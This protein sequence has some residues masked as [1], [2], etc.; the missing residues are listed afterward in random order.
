MT[1]EARNFAVPKRVSQTIT[2]TV[3][4]EPYEYAFTPGKAATAILPVLEGADEQAFVKANFDWLGNGL[5]IE[6]RQH[7]IDRLKNPEDDLDVDTL[8]D[9]IQDLATEVSGDRPTT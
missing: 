8:N 4:D 7:L 6:Q 2:F 3:G 5:P 1:T 9:I